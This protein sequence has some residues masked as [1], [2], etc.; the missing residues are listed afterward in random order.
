MESSRKV[1]GRSK[2][3]SVLRSLEEKYVVAMKKLQFGEFPQFCFTRARSASTYRLARGREG[4]RGHG[5]AG[6]CTRAR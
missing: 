6:H 1:P 3:T 5:W 2:P 4:R